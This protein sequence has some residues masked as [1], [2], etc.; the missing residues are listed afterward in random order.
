MKKSIIILIVVFSLFGCSNQTVLDA[1]KT[2][3]VIQEN[4]VQ[5]IGEEL[6]ES[7]RLEDYVREVFAEYGFETPEE[8]NWIIKY[9]GEEKVAVI[10][11][12][13]EN[14]R[15]YVNKLIFLW[16]G[17]KKDAVLLEVIVD[18]RSVK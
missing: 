15:V 12:I 4:A 17:S 10:I 14:N 18:N 6:S 11:K 5:E 9:E 3:E 2:E 7:D 1:E 13:R 8:S 16:N